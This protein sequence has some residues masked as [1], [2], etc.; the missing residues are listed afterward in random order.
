MAE[1]K[2][3]SSTTAPKSTTAPRVRKRTYLV[4][5]E[6]RE[7]LQKE[8]TQFEERL[9]MLKQLTIAELLYAVQDDGD[10]DYDMEQTKSSGSLLSKSE[11][12][13]VA[14]QAAVDH[15]H[16]VHPNLSPLMSSSYDSH[17]EL[18][19]SIRLGSDPGKW[20]AVFL[21]IKEQKVYRALALMDERSRSMDLTRPFATRDIYSTATGDHYLLFFDVKLLPSVQ[22]VVQVPQVLQFVVKNLEFV[23]SEN[24]Q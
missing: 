7:E 21:A 16:V 20:N 4:R 23:I 18:Y 10:D 15:H 1:L 3:E 2:S 5:K 17:M 19:S 6:E 14:L 22:S 9:A 13:N 12:T 11:L 24:L 8:V